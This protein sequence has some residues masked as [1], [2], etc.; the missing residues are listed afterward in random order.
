MLNR[1]KFDESKVDET[2][3]KT[4]L[5]KIKDYIDGK[6]IVNIVNLVTSKSLSHLAMLQEKYYQV[7]FS[8]CTGN[9][10]RELDEVPEILHSNYCKHMSA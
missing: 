3:V 6:E 10:H 1:P 8:Y 9:L 5:S 4:D 2:A 7:T